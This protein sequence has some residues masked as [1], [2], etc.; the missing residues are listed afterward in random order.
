[1]D[2]CA[3]RPPTIRS[4]ARRSRRPWLPTNGVNTNGVAAEVMD[5]VRWRKKVLVR[6]IYRFWRIG[7]P[8][9]PSVKENKC[10]SDT[11]SADPICPFPK[12][13]LLRPVEE[14]G[15]A[16]RHRLHRELL[17]GLE[18]PG[19]PE[20]L[21]L[22]VDGGGLPEA[23]VGEAALAEPHVGVAGQVRVGGAPERAAEDDVERREGARVQ[24][25]LAGV[26]RDLQAHA[27]GQRGRPEGHLR[28]RVVPLLLGAGERPPRGEGPPPVVREEGVDGVRRTAA[29]GGQQ[30]QRVA[31]EEQ[32]AQRAQ[33][34]PAL[35]QRQRGHGAGEH[36]VAPEDV[37]A[38]ERDDRVEGELEQQGQGAPAPRA[39]GHQQRAAHL[40]RQ[41]HD[42]QGPVRGAR[43]R[44]QEVEEGRAERAR[45]PG[46]VAVG[47]EVPELAPPL[48]GRQPVLADLVHARVKVLHGRDD[49]QHLDHRRGVRPAAQLAEERVRGER[50]QGAQAAAP[51]DDVPPLV[52][53]RVD[54]PLRG[55]EHRGG[56]EEEE[57]PRP[58]QGP[59]RQQQHRGAVRV[60]GLAGEVVVLVEAGQDGDGRQDRRGAPAQGRVPAG[61][62][63][64]EGQEPP[65]A[66]DLPEAPALVVRGREEHDRLPE[67]LRGPQ[68]CTSRGIWR[69]GIVLKHRNS[70]QKEPRPCR[71]MP[72]LM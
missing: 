63:A 71:H 25:P 49:M 69:Q 11:I 16:A 62:E 28:D 5:F 57:E 3:T 19:C 61:V 42:L 59:G 55:H 48:P 1:M 43:Q 56:D 70:L 37:P 12:A 8:Q 10:C 34:R 46:V 2:I 58:L 54:A 32:H 67:E 35:R 47:H 45:A 53:V 27:V 40:R 65:D 22:S 15:Q 50:R 18:G 41:G 21:A 7:A 52:P 6:N 39:E 29:V 44:H 9:S 13:E 33:R 36:H 26:G 31:H 68:K 51:L 64:A 23:A 24:A 72:S 17:Q 66:E 14:P 30:R 4:I 20:R 60:V 38:G